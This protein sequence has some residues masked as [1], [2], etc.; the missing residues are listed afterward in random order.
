VTGG[1]R[2][3]LTAAYAPPVT[4]GR[5]QPPHPHAP[6]HYSDTLRGSKE[7][8]ILLHGRTA[9]REERKSTWTLC[10]DCCRTCCRRRRVVLARRLE[11][12]QFPRLYALPLRR[13]VI[14]PWRASLLTHVC[15]LQPRLPLCL[16][17]VITTVCA[18]R[19]Y[20]NL[21]FCN[22]AKVGLH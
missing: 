13:P 19:N 1:L 20:T 8:T 6:N 18:Q 16:T 21:A 22:T 9:E 7:T 5:T 12:V 2:R 11:H 10:S 17:Q 3:R 14:E 15:Q 4:G